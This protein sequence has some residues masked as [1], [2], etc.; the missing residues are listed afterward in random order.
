MLVFRRRKCRFQGRNRVIEDDARGEEGAHTGEH[1]QH[2]Q[3]VDVFPAAQEHARAARQ[4][5]RILAEERADRFV[6][7]P[8]LRGFP[9]VERVRTIVD[10][11]RT[12]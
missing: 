6:N 9:D 11:V 10:R 8:A 2:L 5:E 12:D 1:L 3:R 7:P 4:D